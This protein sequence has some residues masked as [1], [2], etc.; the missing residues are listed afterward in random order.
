VTVQLQLQDNFVYPS[1]NK[2][3]FLEKSKTVFG[4]ISHAPPFLFKLTKK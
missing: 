3:F 4:R 2:L 1:K